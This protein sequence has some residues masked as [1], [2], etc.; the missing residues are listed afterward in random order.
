MFRKRLVWAVVSCLAT[1]M[2]LGGCSN[3]QS[4]TT[5]AEK[6]PKKPINLIVPYAAGGSADTI[7]R[8]MEKYSVKHLGQP[9]TVTNVPGAGGTLGWNELAGSNP[10]GY[11]MGVVALGCILQP[12]YGQTRYHYPSAIDPLIQ[13]SDLPLL[14]VVR[15]DQPWN[16][17]NDLIKYIHDKPGE[18]KYGHAGLGSAPNLAGEM[19]VKEAQVQVP[20]VPFQGDSEAI[21]ALLGGHVQVIFVNPATIKEY[22]KS[23]KVK[24]LGVTKEQRLSE[25]EFANVPTF[26]EQGYN[27]V[28]SFWQGIGAPKGLPPE[29]RARIVEGLQGLAQDPEFIKTMNDLGFTIEYL[30]SESFS[31]KWIAEKERLGKIVVDTGLAERIKAQKK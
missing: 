7:A 12:L 19:F 23:G 15:S 2:V 22:I 10:D 6:Y 8:S 21:T 16:N 3:S 9:F 31:E 5:M 18:I 25:A 26:K 14:A 13:I 17:L 28:F 24:A 27:V 1:T 4:Q 30:G 20:Q 29:V 11:T